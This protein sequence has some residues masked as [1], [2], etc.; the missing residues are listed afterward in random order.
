MARRGENIYKRKD[1]RW[2]GRYIRG[3]KED[4]KPRYGYVYA[5]TYREVREKLLHVK[6][7]EKP[8]QEVMISE[9][10]VLSAYCDEW[11]LLSRDRVK[12][13]TYVKYFSILHKHIKPALGDVLPDKI[14]SFVIE[15][16]SHSLLTTKQ[17]SPKTVRDILTVLHSVL[18]YISKQ[19]GNEM[20][21][22]EMVYPKNTLHEMRVMSMEEQKQLVAYLLQ[23]MDEVKF[24]VLLTLFTGMRIGEICALK[25]KDIDLENKVISI[26]NTMQRICNIEENASEKT[27]VIVSRAKSSCSQRKIPIT[28][29]CSSLCNAMNDYDPEAFVLTGKENKYMEPRTLQFRFQKYLK[30]CHLEGIH[31][32]TLRHTFATRCVEVDFELKSLSKI[33]GHANPKITLERYVHSSLELQRK[34]MQKLEMLNFS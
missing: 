3:Y 9:R 31:F 10:K 21:M 15:A 22:V 12:E 33:L 11:L 18:V 14:D 4:G 32:H 20:K 25:W 2:E 26:S 16:F 30:V 24:G 28:D 27:K 34:N 1:K 8:V 29:F 13:S 7:T 6:V 23:D 5:K 17:L 19:N